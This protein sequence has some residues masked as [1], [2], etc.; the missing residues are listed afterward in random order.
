MKLVLTPGLILRST[1]CD[2]EIEV[3][4]GTGEAV[5]LCCGGHPMVRVG[6][7]CKLNID[8]N[9]LGGCKSG[10]RYVNDKNTIELFC[11]KSGAGALSIESSLL[12]HVENRVNATSGKDGLVI[13]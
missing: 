13:Y 7:N 12:L 9:F 5:A 8:F 2:A 4:R 11:T 6:D 3:L 1:T 10:H